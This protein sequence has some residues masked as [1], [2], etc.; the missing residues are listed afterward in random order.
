MKSL[1]RPILYLALALLL[2]SSAGSLTSGRFDGPILYVFAAGTALLLLGLLSGGLRA[3]RRAAEAQLSALAWAVLSL[4]LFLLV[5]LAS[6]HNYRRLDFSQARLNSLSPISL[7]VLENSQGPLHLLAFIRDPQA[8]QA[9]R[10]LMEQYRAAY[11]QWTYRIVDPQQEPALAREHGIESPTQAVLESDLGRHRLDLL[12]PN[13]Q[14]R[15]DNEER[16][17]AGV[18]Q[19]TQVE[20]KAAYFLVGHGERDL[21]DLRAEGFRMAADALRAQ[22]YQVR[23]LSLMQVQAV[24]EDARVL[25]AAGPQVDFQP[26]ETDL[27]RDYL[28]NG[29]CLMIMVDP[30]TDFRMDDF[31][32]AYGLALGGDLLLDETAASPVL[33]SIAPLAI[34]DRAHPVTRP[35]YGNYLVFPRAQSVQRRESRL[36][37]GTYGLASTSPRSWSESEVNTAPYSFDSE[38]DR[39][40]P[41]FVAAAASLPPSRLLLVGDSDFAANAYFGE[42]RSG[43]FFVLAV[44]WLMGDA[45]SL[46]IPP[47]S[48]VD[49][50]F[51]ITLGGLR[52]LRWTLLAGLP[53]LPLLAG[54]WVWRRRRA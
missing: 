46:K 45:E 41:H 3:P 34:V 43:D 18:L 49:R 12:F 7:T 4:I 11:P 24:P 9:L 42:Y 8:V 53:L 2:S 32:G 31:L 27:L 40:G 15:P 39:R 47:R 38:E 23:T 17:T 10:H 54:L 30:L 51:R 29:G 33:G 1:R 48:E 19:V 37:Y 20:T 28:D 25:I 35:I 13:Q 21:D 5:N 52:A 44:Q 16:I 14:W 36:G 22:R 6:A 50:R 26:R